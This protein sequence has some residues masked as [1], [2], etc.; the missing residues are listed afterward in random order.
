MHA[1]FRL[2]TIGLLRNKRGIIILISLIILAF[3]L[4]PTAISYATQSDRERDGLAGSVRS[5]VWKATLVNQQNG[6]LTESEAYDV[7][8]VE[9]DKGGTRTR[10]QRYGMCDACSIPIWLSDFH[11][12]V[13]IET[14]LSWPLTFFVHSYD[15]RGNRVETKYYDFF[16]N[17]WRRWIY[18]YELD[19]HGNWTKETLSMID[20]KF[21]NGNSLPVPREIYHRRISYD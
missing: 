8:K 1:Q 10:R 21:F 19:E 15:I 9:Y 7:E 13:R 4:L 5:I 18:Q 2:P 12:R 17:L 6:V 14:Y 3:F 11:G 16:G 20:T